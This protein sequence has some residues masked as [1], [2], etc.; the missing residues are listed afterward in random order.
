MD[1]REG[2]VTLQVDQISDEYQGIESY[3]YEIYDARTLNENPDPVK[4]HYEK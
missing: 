4:N 3:R 1:K 2:A